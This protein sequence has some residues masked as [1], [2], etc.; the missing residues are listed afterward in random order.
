MSHLMRLARSR[1]R[2][3]RRATSTL[4]P[5]PTRTHTVKER[6]ALPILVPVDYRARVELCVHIVH[7][8]Y[9]PSLYT[10]THNATYG[11]TALPHKR[12][13]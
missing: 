8:S 3:V 6:C 11:F 2:A 1:G 12:T 7:M 5:Y 9:V 13:F 4:I 10:I